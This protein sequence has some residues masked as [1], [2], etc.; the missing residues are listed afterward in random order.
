MAEYVL[1]DG[2]VDTLR[3]RV[4]W[5]RDVDDLVAE[6]E[7]H[8]Y[9]TVERFE[10]TGTD[11]Q[12]A[13]RRTL[14]R[15]GDPDLMADAF[16]STPR[17]GIAVPTKFTKTA[18]LAAIFA[19]VLWLVAVA[20]YWL[21]Q[22]SDGNGTYFVWSAIVLA[23]GALT[24]VT[25]VGLRQRHG[26]LGRLGTVGLVIL[27]F[28]V[29]FSIIAWAAPFWM[30][31]QGVGMLFVALAAMPLRVAPRLPMI[32]YG[33]GMLLGSITFVVAR[34]MEVGTVDQWGDY[35]LANGIGVTVGLAVTA[36]GLTGLGW[37]LRNEEPADIDTTPDQA[38]T[39]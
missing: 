37:W 23:A 36:A 16:A 35:P 7:D 2:Y 11:S 20:V 39:A 34:A 38:I 24:F 21:G 31:V 19:S 26:T 5:R 14:D 12:L 29:V 18:G 4:R 32:A 15:F 8:L 27:G 13:Q 25:T 9:S 28:G 30:A 6:V 33:S 3:T 22:D 17:G 10:A 1:I